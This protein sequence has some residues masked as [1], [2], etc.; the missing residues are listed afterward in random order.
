[1]T[2]KLATATFAL[3]FLVA[4]APEAT[5]HRSYGQTPD[6]PPLVLAGDV[7]SAERA[8]GAAEGDSEV[9]VPDPEQPEPAIVWVDTAEPGPSEFPLSGLPDFVAEPEDLTKV[10]FFAEPEDPDMVCF[11]PVADGSIH[12]CDLRGEPRPVP[13]PGYEP[14]P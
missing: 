10:Y 13:G 2:I 3:V 9:L 4:W 5:A 8:S 1:M 11:L 6:Q 14:A 7:G 12:V